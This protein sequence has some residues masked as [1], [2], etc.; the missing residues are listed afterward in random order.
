MPVIIPAIF[1]DDAD[2][3]V[4]MLRASEEFAPEVHI[5][6]TDGSFVEK[7]SVA[8]ADLAGMRSEIPVEVHLMVKEPLE[9]IH[10]LTETSIRR[11]ILH[12][13]VV[14]EARTVPGL[15]R[16]Q[17]FAIGL[18]VNPDTPIVSLYPWLAELD[19]AVVMG[20]IPGERGASLRTDT[21]NKIRELKLMWPRGTISTDGG[22]NAKTIPAVT[23]AG[24][25]RIIVATALW[26]SADPRSEYLALQRLT[27][28]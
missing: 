13:E 5:D 18:A 28:R 16:R 1:T 6:V 21:P 3:L 20:V 27:N 4:R 23:Q 7:R 17:G 11:I 8:I 25:D 26:Q 2:A 24:A 14:R 12:S 22:M 15:L 10:Q 19:Q 9:A